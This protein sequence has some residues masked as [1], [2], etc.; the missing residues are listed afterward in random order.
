M[1]NLR[2][3]LVYN[4]VFPQDTGNPFYPGLRKNLNWYTDPENSQAYITGSPFRFMNRRSKA[5]ALYILKDFASAAEIL[6]EVKE[7]DWNTF[8]TDETLR[9]KSWYVETW[10]EG[11]LGACYARLGMSDKALIQLKI[12]DSMNSG[13]PK[14]TNRMLRGIVP[15]YQARIYAILGE[16]QKAVEALKRSKE[17]GRMCE[18]GN[19]IQDWDLV[20]LSDYQPFRDLVGL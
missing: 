10:V 8:I 13:N 19:F 17:E 12:L 2:F 18:H 14:T 4:E 1:N 20:S 9:K 11:L 6:E 3:A 15:Y 5:N 16:K 7:V